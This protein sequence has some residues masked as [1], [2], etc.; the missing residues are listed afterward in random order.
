MIRAR[1]AAVPPAWLAVVGITAALAGCGTAHDAALSVSPSKPKP[2]S[3]ITF[4]FTAPQASGVTGQSELSYSLS[5][6]GPASRPGCVGVHEATAPSVAKDKLVEIAV[7][8]AQLHADWCSGPYTAQVFELERAACSAGQVCA[9][10][11]RIV[12][13]VGRVSFAVAS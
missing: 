13:T 10:Y 9:Q 1:I 6:T 12:R 11:I 2:G 4:A 7:G 8:P 3:E 5:V